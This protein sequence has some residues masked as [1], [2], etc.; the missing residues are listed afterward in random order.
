MPRDFAKVAR[1]VARGTVIGQRLPKHGALTL[2]YQAV[3]GRVRYTLVEQIR[4][5]EKQIALK[6]LWKQRA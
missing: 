6:S 1:I 3:L 2:T 5:G 4:S